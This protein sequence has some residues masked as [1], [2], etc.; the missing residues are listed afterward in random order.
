MQIE[1]Y[2]KIVFFWHV[3]LS[4]SFILANVDISKK[5]DELQLDDDEFLEVSIS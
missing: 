2:N 1:N 4:L 5:R 3:Y